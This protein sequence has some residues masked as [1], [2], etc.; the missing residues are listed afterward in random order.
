M[1]NINRFEGTT[2][3]KYLGR[4]TITKN[5]QILLRGVKE[6]IRIKDAIECKRK[7]IGGKFKVFDIIIGYK[8]RNA[9]RKAISIAV[10]KSVYGFNHYS[11]WDVIINKESLKSK[12]PRCSAPEI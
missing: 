1:K 12:C 9:F 5:K 7:Y 2:N 3:I 4:Y 11:N 8:A 6:L 10:L